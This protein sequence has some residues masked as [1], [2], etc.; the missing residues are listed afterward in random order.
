M[1][2]EKSHSAPIALGT[3]ESVRK[4]HAKNGRLNCNGHGPDR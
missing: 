4:N 2:D 3:D 1:K